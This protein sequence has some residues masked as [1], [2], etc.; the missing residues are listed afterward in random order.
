MHLDKNEDIWNSKEIVNDYHSIYL[1]NAEKVIL[2]EVKKEISGGKMLDIGVGGGR[3]AFF[4]SKLVK[5]YVG[6]DYS[7]SMIQFCKQVV[8]KALPKAF[9]MTCDVRLLKPFSDEYFDLCLFSYNGLDYVNPE[10]RLRALSE[11][12]R[13]TKSGGYF[14]FSTHNLYFWRELFSFRRIKTL[15]DFLL[16]IRRVFRLCYFNAAWTPLRI[17]KPNYLILRDGGHDFNLRTFYVKPEFEVLQLQTTGFRH[18][19]IFKG[20]SGD[21]I[22]SLLDYRQI[23]EPWVYFLCK[24]D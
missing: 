21:E 10:G 24:K 19:R 5:E 9:F 3:T 13:V 11:I 2:N 1:E 15:K 12:Y 23:K 16:E 18:I 14:A 20:S 4:F 17:E 22:S 6:I 7:E 8:Q